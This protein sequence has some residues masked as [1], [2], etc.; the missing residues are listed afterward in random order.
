[1]HI[2]KYNDYE[3]LY[4]IKRKNEIALDIIYSKYKIYL[5]YK[6]KKY[7]FS[8]EFIDDIVQDCLMEMTI[9]LKRFDENRN[10]LFFTFIDVIFERKI[11]KSL[12]KYYKDKNIVEYCIEKETRSLKE[13]LCWYELLESTN[14]VKTNLD[15][16]NDRLLD[17]EKSVLSNIMIN[18]QSISNFAKQHNV[19]SKQVYNQIQSIRNKY[20]KYCVKKIK[21]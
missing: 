17:K 9:S 18:N 11:N 20:V 12:I 1:M 2:T 14:I 13:E 8:R 6:L 19:S 5:Y 7:T 4:L 15:I 16:L 10:I 21:K 3:L